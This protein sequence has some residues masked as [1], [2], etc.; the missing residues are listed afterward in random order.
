MPVHVTRR[1][2]PPNLHSHEYGGI[3]APPHLMLLPAYTVLPFLRAPL[4]YDLVRP[5]MAVIRT[6]ALIILPAI[7]EFMW[8]GITKRPIVSSRVPYLSLFALA[9]L[10]LSVIVF[11]RRW[12][13]QRRGEEL[14]SGEAGHSWLA[15]YTRLPIPLCELIITPMLV[16]GAGYLMAGNVSNE[17]GWWLE[18][19][20]A[21]LF[22][23]ALWEYRRTWSQRRATMDDVVRA[24]AFEARVDRV[25]P[26]AATPR[27][28][29][30]DF[31]D[32]A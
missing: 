3:Q 31:A 18:A 2:L 24:K 6:G 5:G 4:G 17:L 10:V 29:G 7:V 1:T 32:L 13:G 11:A 21:S 26:A 8:V 9:Y 20:G 23:M 12:L 30:P 22:V 14:H 28:D 27:Q 25:T 15:R 16:A 19:A